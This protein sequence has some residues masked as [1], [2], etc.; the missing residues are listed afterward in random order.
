MV[1][2]KSILKSLKQFQ[3]KV[4]SKNHYKNKK[5]PNVTYSQRWEATIVTIVPQKIDF[6]K[7]PRTSLF[8]PDKARASP[9]KDWTRSKNEPICRG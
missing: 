6:S 5:V 4:H 8:S 3:S 7:K 2:T 1:F 9:N